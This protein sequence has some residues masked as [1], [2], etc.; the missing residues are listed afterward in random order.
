MSVCAP[1]P[2]SAV[3]AELR[4][5]LRERL[6]VTHGLNAI[7]V[8]RPFFDHLEVWPD[9]LLPELRVA[10]EYDTTGRHGLEHVGRRQK[11]DERK[12]RAIR[13][14]GWEV[15]RIRTGKLAKLGEH[16][17]QA[18]GVTRTMYVRLFDELR[19]IRGDLI[20]DAYLL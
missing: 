6:A 17:V 8:A 5:E 14:A 7:T 13:A 9:I 2:A 20:V 18:S 4:A 10:I 16:D 1:R 3:E 11:V 19:A 15:V 12:D